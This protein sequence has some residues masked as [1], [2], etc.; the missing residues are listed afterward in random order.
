M[1]LHIKKDGTAKSYMLYVSR[2]FVPMVASLAISLMLG[3]TSSAVGIAAVI[4]T[5]FIS[6]LLTGRSMWGDELLLQEGHLVVKKAGAVKHD[7]S[8]SQ[9]VECKHRR[10]TLVLMWMEN[11]KRAG[12]IIGYEAF[13][14]ETWR[15]LVAAVEELKPT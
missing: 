7:V 10:N 13:L 4:L 3:M 15:Q 8:L 9:L 14:P 11:G 5:G 2:F 1:D 12:I 6:L